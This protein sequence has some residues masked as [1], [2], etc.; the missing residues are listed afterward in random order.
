[1]VRFE[2]FFVPELHP[3]EHENGAKY[4]ST[5]TDAHSVDTQGRFKYVTLEK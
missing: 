2:A 4:V 5:V 3:T 1:M